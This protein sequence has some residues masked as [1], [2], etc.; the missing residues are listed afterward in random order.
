MD[1]YNLPRAF[2][3]AQVGGHDDVRHRTG[4]NVHNMETLRIACCQLDI[5]PGETEQN[6]ERMEALTT[7]ASQDGANLVVFPELTTS[8][9]YVDEFASLADTIPGEQSGA[10]SRLAASTGTHIAVGLLEDTPVGL[11]NIAVLFS[12]RGDIVG[13]YR[14]THLSVSSRNGTIAKEADVFL[15]GDDLPVFRTDFGIVGMMICKDGDYPEVPRVL[16][17]K[18]AEIILWMTNRD[19]VNRHSSIHYARSNCVALIAANRAKGHAAGGES[20]IFDWHGNVLDEASAEESVL[21]ADIDMASMKADRRTH[22][23]VSRV[24]RPQLYTELAE[25]MLPNKPDAG[26][27]R[28]VGAPDPRR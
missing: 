24:R 14:K 17:V 3:A 27:P 12:P 28:T 22:W 18:G 4:R 1:T 13:E 2:G 5:V 10:V 11:Y 9:Y 23:G 8:D 6:L 16:A 21:C 26:T 15:P 25:E 7:Q 19:G 20:A